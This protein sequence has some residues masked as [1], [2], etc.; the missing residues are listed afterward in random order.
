M[1]TQKILC[2]FILGTFW[3]CSSEPS[4]ERG[5]LTGLDLGQSVFEDKCT[6]CHGNDGRKGLVGAKTIPES[7]FSVAERIELI[8][9]GKGKMMPYEGILTPEEIKAVAEYTATLK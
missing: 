3:T 4:A 9:R 1:R 8:S 2:F 7:T 5:T 6:V